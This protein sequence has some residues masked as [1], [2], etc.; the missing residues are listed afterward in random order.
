MK[1]ICVHIILAVF[2]FIDSGWAQAKNTEKDLPITSIN[3]LAS[4]INK[5]DINLFS[6][7]CENAKYGDH[8]IF[9]TSFNISITDKLTAKEKKGEDLQAAIK[10]IRE[11]AEIPDLCADETVTMMEQAFSLYDR[12][13]S[14]EEVLSSG[15]I[16]TKTML[17]DHFA[18]LASQADFYQ[19]DNVLEIFRNRNALVLSFQANI[20]CIILCK[21]LCIKII[22]RSNSSPDGWAQNFFK[23]YLFKIFFKFADKIIVN[24]LDFKKKFKS[25]FN[26]NSVCI[27]NP[28]NKK[29]ILKKSKIKLK[30]KFNKN[31]LNLINVGRIVDQKDQITILRSLNEIKH[32]IDF[33]LLL[34]GNG[35]QKKYLLDFVIKNH[36]SK[37]VKFISFQK[38]PYNLIK[39]SDIF[40]LSSK[41]EGLPNV[42]LEAQVLKTYIMSSNCPTGPREIL[43]NGK[44]GSLFDVGDYKTLSNLILNFSKKKNYQKTLIGFKNL[45]RFDY[46]NN[47]EKYF[48]TINYF[49]KKD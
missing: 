4:K 48:Y 37:C 34:V 49:I 19:L 13:N 9:C 30:I 16:I 23:F 33:R 5:N 25:K 39:N 18:R 28:L 45:S 7:D 46:K 6:I 35:V 24:S 32:K 31:K 11:G 17:D 38:N 27:Y 40:I 20:Y 10:E 44:A 47:L 22:V 36:L 43:M 41:Y 26:L 12:V 29:E 21:L 3:L 14:G 1:N 42:L 2:V 15:K 8:K